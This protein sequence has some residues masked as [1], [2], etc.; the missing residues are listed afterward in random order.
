MKTRAIAFFAV[1]ILI[2]MIPASGMAI[3]AYNQDFEGLN[4]TGGSAL[5][6]DGWLVFANVFGPGGTPYLYGYGVF[7]APND[8]GGFC[9]IAVGEGGAGQGSQQLNIFSDYNNVD[10]AVGNVIEANTF[11][12]MVIGAGDVGETWV[13]D[14]DA[15]LANLAGA[16][17][18]LAFIKTLNPAAGF[19]TTNFI[20]ED[21]TS[22]PASWGSYSLSI[23]I[24]ASLV[25][26]LL[27]IGFSS[28]CTNYEGSGVFYDNVN[29]YPAG[30]VATEDMSWGGVKSLFR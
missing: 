6:D 13:F 8:G 3:E 10:H 21:T 16:S 23:D 7:G 26:Q 30:P 4:Q 29:F 20:T 5:A 24:D 22:I 27:Q 18:A 15:K 11:Q 12:E 19:A 28:N 25:G 17:T 9:Q 14:F 1:A 2:S